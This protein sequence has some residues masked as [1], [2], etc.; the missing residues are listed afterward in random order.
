MSYREKRSKTNVRGRR[1]SPDKSSAESAQLS[2]RRDIVELLQR[3]GKPQSIE[4][5]SEHLGHTDAKTLQG[6]TGRLAAMER[7]GQ[8]I[9][10]RRGRYGLAQ[11]MDLTAGRVI[12]HRDGFGFVSQDAPGQDLYLSP[13]E[14]RKV[15]HG[16]RVLVATIK[17]DRR[18]RLEGSVVEI[19]E[20]AHETIVGRY[21]AEGDSGF[22]IP[23]DRRLSQDVLVSDRSMPVADGDLVV[24]RLTRQPE[25][26][27]RP[28]GV[29]Q[30]VLGHELTPALEVDLVLYK[31]DLPAE[32]NHDVE[33]E[34]SGLG[35]EVRDKEIKAR[36]DL[37]E[38]PFVTID[39]ADAK[40]FD[41]AVYCE[42]HGG[43]WRLAVA[44]ADVSNYVTRDSALDEEALRRGTSV[45]FPGRVIPMLPEELSNGLCSLKP[46]VDRLALVCWMD[47]DA[48]GGIAEYRFERA[49]IH[50]HG[51][52]TYDQV[53]EF[54]DQGARL[55]VADDWQPAVQQNVHQ[56]E[57][58]HAVL[59][60]VKQARGALAFESKEVDLEFEDDGSVKNFIV[61][62]RNRAHTIIEE[63][64]VAANRCAAEFLDKRDIPV[65][66]RI[67]D[68][69]DEEK[70]TG[71]RQL[72]GSLQLRL[73]GEGVPEAKEM[74]ELLSSVAERSDAAMIQMMVLRSLKQAVYSP[75]ASGHYG[76][77][78]DYYAHFTS[79]I[80]RYPDLLVHRAI[81]HCIG[82]KKSAGDIYSQEQMIE[83]GEHCS[84]VERRAEEATRDL[85]AAYKCRFIANH[86]GEEFEGVVSGVTAFGLFV[87]IND[88]LIDGLVHVSSLR[89]DYYHY[90]PVLQR[91]SAEHG[92]EVFRLGDSV[93]VTV[94]RA[95]VEDRKIDFE[96]VDH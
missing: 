52:L 77:A 17:V 88:L 50:S 62:E 32:W 16:D 40:D 28:M 29:I 72:L 8:V 15:F 18:G 81:I 6:L 59:Q 19:L 10:G 57:Q 11:K 54:L 55:P 66:H 74:T 21:Q 46:A 9:Q 75:Q 23:E 92:G 12:G 90:D 84:M 36:K 39:G 38:L 3:C 51:R 85:M 42:P 63:C 94:M 43:G 91:L 80:R 1:R 96:L 58:L 45:Y 61:R 93:R 33:V 65:L 26:R 41:D 70:I 83:L 89:N 53:A 34:V 35:E 2:S 86:I 78:L 4:E 44:I 73:P 20:R 56:L 37:R 22:V 95:A 47:F 27:R 67:H 87:T 69:P 64:M 31:Y 48:Q 13:K 82:D 5:L 60:Q 71:L 14:M 24:V 49:A 30:E 79:P 25:R 76:M 7:D 68:E